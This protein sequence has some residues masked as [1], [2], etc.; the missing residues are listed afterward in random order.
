VVFSIGVVEGT[1][2]T[3]FM[4]FITNGMESLKTKVSRERE[5]ETE[6]EREREREKKK[7]K[8]KEKKSGALRNTTLIIRRERGQNVC[9]SEG[10]QA[11]PARPSGKCKLAARCFGKWSR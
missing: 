4:F 1:G 5:R 3:N 11:V 7:K 10:S 6:R 2:I 9:C 8:K